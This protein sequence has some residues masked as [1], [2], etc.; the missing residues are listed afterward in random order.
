V[1]KRINKLAVNV[2]PDKVEPLLE[3]LV[4]K[5]SEKNQL[6]IINKLN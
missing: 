5:V 2:S 6:E 4:M 1:E 3:E